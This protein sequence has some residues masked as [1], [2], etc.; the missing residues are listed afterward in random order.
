MSLSYGFA[1]LCGASFGTGN[2]AFTPNGNS[3]AVPCG[4]RLTLHDLRYNQVQTLPFET[5][6]NARHIV[7]SPRDP[8]L[9][10]IDD[11]G[12]ALVVNAVKNVVLSRPRFGHP[13][14]DAKFSPCGAYVAVA[15][16]RKVRIYGTPSPAT[17]WQLIPIRT[18]RNHLDNVVSVDWSSDSRFLCSASNDLTVRLMTR[19]ELDGF[20]PTTLVDHRYPVKAAFFSHDMARIFS[21]ARDGS[22]ICWRWLPAPAAEDPTTTEDDEYDDTEPEFASARSAGMHLGKRPRQQDNDKLVLNPHCAI[23]KKR[24]TTATGEAGAA[25]DA[26]AGNTALSQEGDA[27]A[28]ASP[29]NARMYV[30]G[31]WIMEKKGYCK[32]PRGVFVNRCNFLAKLGLLLVGFTNGAASLYELPDFTTLY[33]LTAGDQAATTTAINAD[34]EW[35]ALGCAESGQLLVWEWR[36]ESFIMKQQGHNSGAVRSVACSP[37]Y[38]PVS[39]SRLGGEKNHLGLGNQSLIVA[40]GGE[41]GKVKLWDTSSGFNYMTFTEHTAA[42]NALTFTPQVGLFFLNKRNRGMQSCRRVPTAAFGDSIWRAIG[43]FERSLLPRRVLPLWR[44]L[45]MELERPLWL[46]PKALKRIRSIFGRS[47]QANLSKP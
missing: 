17:N 2:V 28:M 33:A 37:A 31:R 19:E 46:P 16:E 20:S 12:C 36:S 13:V 5:I 1:N 21:V 27:A 40:T 18:V 39:Q 6:C 22:M 11:E 29:S 38:D 43:I 30:D 44:W 9:I 23:R 42:V 15:V 45:W 24:R 47:R 3:L 14:A 35:I 41:D 7:F 26:A 25:A 32:Q 8:I 10:V 34:G 4:N